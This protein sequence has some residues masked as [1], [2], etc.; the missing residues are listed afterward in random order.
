MVIGGYANGKGGEGGVPEGGV[1]PG[2]DIYF[3]LFL[4][5][6]LVGGRYPFK[7]VY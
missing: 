3:H 2:F 4:F 1:V 7:R 6:R 5:V